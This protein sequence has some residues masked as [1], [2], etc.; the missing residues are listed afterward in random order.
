MHNARLLDSIQYKE[1]ERAWFEQEL[2]KVKNGSAEGPSKPQKAG[3][4]TGLP[5]MLPGSAVSAGFTSG[6]V[7][8]LD[9]F[10]DKVI[11]VAKVGTTAEEHK[12]FTIALEKAKIQTLY[13]EKRVSE[14]LSADDASIF[15]THL[16]I[17]EDRGFIS[18]IQDL[19]DGGHSAGRAVNEVVSHY[20]NAFSRM[21]D[22]YLRAR[23]EDIRE[24]G[25]RI[26]FRLRSEAVGRLGDVDRSPHRSHQQQSSRAGALRWGC[27]DEAAGES[28]RIQV[29]RCSE[30]CSR[31]GGPQRRVA[32]H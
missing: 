16:M 20:V 5:V 8:I 32:P 24:V 21:E 18:K 13:M 9:R 4:R 28:R 26:L 22:P 7:Y 19:V 3:K 10:S 14:T 15:H 2:A 31:E 11:K 23:A 29:L 27:P 1:Q 12:K 17:L 25:R 6:K 30:E